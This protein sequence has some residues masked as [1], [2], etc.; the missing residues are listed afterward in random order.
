MRWDIIYTSKRVVGG[1]LSVRPSALFHQE[2]F[3]STGR[4]S[5]RVHWPKA[6]NCSGPDL[7]QNSAGPGRCD[8]QSICAEWKFKPMLWKQGCLGTPY[9]NCSFCLLRDFMSPHN[10]IDEVIAAIVTLR[11]STYSGQ[12]IRTEELLT[13]LTECLK[14]LSWTREW[15]IL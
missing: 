4:E 11:Y 2:E 14:R 1:C 8:S 9:D 5:L 13:E 3:A 7:Y 6:P 12:W 10:C 15:I